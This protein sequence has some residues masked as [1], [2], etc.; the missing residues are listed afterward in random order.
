M[1]MRTIIIATVVVFVS[2]LA[3]N[4]TA[5]ALRPPPKVTNCPKPVDGAGKISAVGVTC[6]TAYAV[7]HDAM[8]A[9]H[10]SA[11]R[12]VFDLSTKGEIWHVNSQKYSVVLLKDVAT[13]KHG[14]RV[15][16]YIA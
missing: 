12:H 15:V 8:Y 2:M 11:P 1:K 9:Y 7:V 6:A 4:F 14:H 3:V 5:L 13:D 10:H 16:F